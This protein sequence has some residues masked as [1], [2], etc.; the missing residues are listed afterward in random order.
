MPDTPALKPSALNRQLLLATIALSLIALALGVRLALDNW[1]FS[2]ERSFAQPIATVF[3]AIER[4][5]YQSPDRDAL[6]LAAINGMV[7]ALND[8]YTEFIPAAD[9]AEFDKQIRGEFVG[10]GAEIRSE[11]GLLRIVSPLD[12]SPALRAGVQAGDI[13]LGVNGRS[14]VNMTVD[15]II[16]ELTGVPG[17][18]VR[19]TI[20]R[21]A[22]QSLPS[23]ALPAVEP[24][25]R[26]ELAEQNMGIAP[27]PVEAG[28]VRFDLE[29]TRQRIRTETIRGLVRDGESWD[30]FVDPATRIAYIRITQFTDTT[31]PRLREYCADLFLTGDA[32]G[33]ILDLR[34][35]AGGSLLA[36]VE[37]ADL[38]IAEGTIVSLMGRTTQAEHA[39]A[40]RE[41]TLPDFPMIVLVN[42]ESASASEVVAGAL[43]ENN[44]AI[45]L[46]ERTFGKGL[47]QG[48]YPLAGDIGQLKITEQHY[49][50]PSGRVIHRQDDSTQW[51]VDPSPGYFVAMDADASLLAFRRRQEA[52]VLRASGR[53]EAQDWADPAWILEHFADAQLTAAVVALRS[54]IN[55]GQ[56]QPPGDDQPEVAAITAAYRAETKRLDALVQELDRIEAR[57]R[58]LDASL[59]DGSGSASR[60]IPADAKLNEG[61]IEIRDASGQLITTLRITS[62][63]IAQWLRLAPLEP[64]GEPAYP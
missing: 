29:I 47:V 31:A 3:G 50:L 27:L 45:V 56:W 53:D 57:L 18:T 62:D 8:P 38:F 37:T 49:A 39:E 17:T 33:L 55:D 58:T 20:E 42:S 44:R 46:G 24:E 54:K 5:F 21:D 19:I 64:A 14:I 25:P 40:Y 36:A 4:H 13:V 51:G 23:G 15:A 61:T 22:G 1:V 35:N 41:G 30:F 10:I 11:A 52:E 63:S 43:L 7:A 32:K 59:P 26:A 9:T 34:Y 16:G 60:L 12:D 6:Q 28:R 48:I 2:S